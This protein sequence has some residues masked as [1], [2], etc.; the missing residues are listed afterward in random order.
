MNGVTAED[1]GARLAFDR[2]EPGRRAVDVPRWEGQRAELP[3]AHLLR[4]RTKTRW[5]ESLRLSAPRPGP[6]A[7][8]LLDRIRS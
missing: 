4:D 2:S 7:V 3:D 8:C 1:F 6:S 5:S